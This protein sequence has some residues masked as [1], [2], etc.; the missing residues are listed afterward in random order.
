MEFKS[1]SIVKKNYSYK[2]LLVKNFYRDN[3]NFT[4]KFEIANKEFEINMNK[5]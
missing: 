1:Y 2:V 5:L 4:G 3:K